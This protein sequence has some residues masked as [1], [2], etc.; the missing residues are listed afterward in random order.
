MYAHK[1]TGISIL[2]QTPPTPTSPGRRTSSEASTPGSDAS[3]TCLDVEDAF[4]EC[5]ETLEDVVA[6][7]QSSS[8]AKDQVENGDLQRRGILK[9]REIISPPR[10]D[11][12]KVC[13]APFHVI[14][15]FF[16]RYL[17]IDLCQEG[18]SYL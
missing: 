15:S 3:I 8:G 17:G 7:T 5:E 11:D 4:K 16:F 10:E 9:R 1:N 18:V 13:L 14:R 12:L 2:E 6:E